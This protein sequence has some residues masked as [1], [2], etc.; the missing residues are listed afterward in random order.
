MDW[1]ILSG[2][3]IAAYLIGSLP[4]GFII[5][6]Q[7]KGIDIRTVGSGSTGAT[8]VKRVLGTKFFIIVMLLDMLKG[9]LP[10]VALKY[11]NILPAMIPD[12]HILTIMAAILLIVG[13][14]KSIYLG[15]TGGKSVATSVG[16]L[17]ALSWQAALCAIL[18]WILIVFI[19][20]YVS[21][22]SIIAVLLT[23]LLMWLFDQP[24]SYIIFTLVSG[25]YVALYLHR[26]NIKKLL[27]G[28][29]NKTAFLGEK[30]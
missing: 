18:L 21:L 19:T 28:T 4:T 24:V 7:L 17:F 8:N 22:G 10:L 9:L 5:V 25:L 23:P 14:S 15:F 26:D 16:V 30:K 6:K 1:L 13:H 3:L 27:D 12:I 2:I 20:K 29:E 11:F